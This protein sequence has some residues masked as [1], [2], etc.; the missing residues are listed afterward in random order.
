MMKAD[1]MSK[2]VIARAS[3]LVRAAGVMSE[4]QEYWYETDD[5]ALWVRAMLEGD[6]A[7]AEQ[8]TLKRRDNVC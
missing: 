7:A 3:S 1:M 2:L 5:D 4:G 8:V 6:K